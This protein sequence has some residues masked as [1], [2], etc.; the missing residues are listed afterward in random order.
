[1]L[2]TLIRFIFACN[3][4]TGK[5]AVKWREERK[6]HA[7]AAC[8]RFAIKSRALTFEFIP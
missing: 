6:A 3:H 7:F 1:M 5:S 2:S 8:L 4:L